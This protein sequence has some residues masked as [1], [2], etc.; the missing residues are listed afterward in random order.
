MSNSGVGPEKANRTLLEVFPKRVVE[1][2]TDVTVVPPTNGYAGSNLAGE[3]IFFTKFNFIK[4][5][6]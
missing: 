1:S 6:Y 3:Q 2:T 5:L 4:S